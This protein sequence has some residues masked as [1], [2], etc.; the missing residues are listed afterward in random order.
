MVLPY[1]ESSLLDVMHTAH[2]KVCAC[3]ACL[4]G[5]VR[6]LR[7]C[8]M[9]LQGLPHKA[10]VAVV[11]QLLQGLCALHER[12]II[13]RDIKVRLLVWLHR[14]LL[15][16]QSSSLWCAWTIKRLPCRPATSWST[17]GA[18]SFWRTWAS[19]RCSSARSARVAAELQRAHS[20]LWSRQRR[21]QTR[22]WGPPARLYQYSFCRRPLLMLGHALCMPEQVLC[23]V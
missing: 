13:H 16:V 4:A 21:R 12:G 2:P 14:G 6:E 10:L 15:R 18:T 17:S 9:R 19:P 22:R 1:M 3:A 8:R 23:S 7:R 5:R 11:R 20:P